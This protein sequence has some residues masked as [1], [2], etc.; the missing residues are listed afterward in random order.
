MKRPFAGISGAFAAG[1]P[2]PVMVLLARGTP[3]SATDPWTWIA[4]SASL[5]LLISAVV[6]ALRPRAGRVFAGIGWVG[7]FVVLLP[8]LTQSPSLAL[9]TML[10]IVFLLGRLWGI[11][12]P[13]THPIFSRQPILA[14]RARS[15]AMV[16]VVLAIGEYVTSGAG[17]SP[18]VLACLFCSWIVS[19][20]F[21]A[22]WLIDEGR[23]HR[24]RAIVMLAALLASGA[25]CAASWGHWRI[26]WAAAV[27]VSA[28]AVA[29][30]P[31]ERRVAGAIAAWSGLFLEHAER[32]LVSTF[33]L[34][35]LAGTL[36]LALPLSSTAAGSIGLVDAAFTSVS[37]V[38]VTGL[39][40]LDTPHDFTFFG[41]AVILV[42]IQAGG[43]GIM[44]FSTAALR[45]LGRRLSL[46]HEAAVAGL[47]NVQ[48]RSKLFDSVRRLIVLTL[49][50]E[51]AGVLMLLPAFLIR[52]DGFFMALWRALFTSVSAFCNAG[53]ALQSDSL[54]PYRTDGW[55]LQTV[56]ALIIL[57]GLSP[58]VVA[59]LPHLLRR[60]AGVPIQVRIVVVTSV[61]LLV[62]GFAFFL[63]I[64]WGGS[65]S[66]LSFWDRI[67]NAWLQSATL[68]T[69]GFNSVPMA[70]L[71]PTVLSLMMVLMFIGGSPGSTAGGIK[72]TTAAVLGLAVASAV[73]GR[74]EAS[75]FKRHIPHKTVYKAAAIA[76]VGAG[77]TL[78]ALIGVQLTQSMPE[79]LA[80][81]EVVSALGTVGLS[82]GGT[83]LLDGVGKVI[84]IACMFLGRVGPLSLF[85]FLSDR[86][87]RTAWKLP[88]EEIDVG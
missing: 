40:V 18:G 57:G 43:L 72:T 4:A 83:A 22:Q 32:L 35:C 63:A 1:S 79:R 15:A 36:L 70:G 3:V 46:R 45:L 2:F 58:P 47:I 48:D 66:G 14:A 27:A 84:I 59:A 81:F 26:C 23:S 21:L 31:V 77:V 41:Q 19:A 42:L 76:T 67:H 6:L 50:V 56:A 62:V 82:L 61:V 65:L 9:A 53:F 30:L 13:P 5:S 38:C 78:A 28:I 37:A 54:I 69:A 55:I 52:G 68:R 34:L 8:T 44:S 25:V 7:S 29:A 49:G 73:R 17:R 33:A 16:V 74:W 71:D 24:G 39:I 51:A 80:L 64:E 10:A 12:E 88:A 86:A 20:V 11:I 75:A 85:I 60:E 87:Y